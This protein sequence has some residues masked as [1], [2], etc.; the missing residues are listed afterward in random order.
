MIK[1]NNKSINRLL[2][3]T[4]RNNHI[5]KKLF[6]NYFSTQGIT[7]SSKDNRHHLKTTSHLYNTRFAIIFKIVANK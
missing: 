5:N 6:D 4:V 2:E 7:E 1:T 3:T